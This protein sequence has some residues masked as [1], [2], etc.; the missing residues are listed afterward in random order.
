MRN[1]I[2]LSVFLF[3]TLL[4]VAGSDAIPTCTFKTACAT[5]ETCLFE[6]FQENNTH[7]GSCDSPYTIKVCCTEITSAAI[8]T[9]CVAGEGGV[10]S[11]YQTYDSHAGSKDY[12]SNVVCAKTANNPVLTIMRPTCLARERC[13]VSVYQENNTHVGHCDYYSTKVC[14]QEDFNV[15]ITMI[16]NV[17]EPNWNESVM[18]SG[19]ATRA[20]GSAIDTSGDPADVEVYLNDTSPP[21]KICTTD[22]NSTGGYT[23]NFTAPLALGSYELNVTV[24][25]PTTG[26]TSS[27]TTMFTIKQKL[28]EA[29]TIEKTAKD[30]AC[31]EE[32]RVV[33]NPD[34]TIEIAIVRI[35]VWK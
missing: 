29:P 25:D 18:L 9:S 14:I 1:L 30:I 35:C 20:D 28:G 11:M 27:N 22:T 24:D 4:F 15:T 32:P 19:V 12:Y 6:V 7:V 23:C 26:K 5:G 33:Q 34:G 17:T 10:I 13:V 3:L 16:L 21:R 2:G 31:F 8:R